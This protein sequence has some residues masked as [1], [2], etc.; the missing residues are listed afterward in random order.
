MVESAP[1]IDKRLV[2]ALTVLD[3]S[4]EPM[5]EI[6]RRVGALA[7][8]LDL[9]RPSYSQ[10]RRLLRADRLERAERREHRERVAVAI[11]TRRHAYEFFSR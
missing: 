2:L 11:V 5:A 7:R 3:D 6:N 10:I 1:R 4:R 9:P 8:E